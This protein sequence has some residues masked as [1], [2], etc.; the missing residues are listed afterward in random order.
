MRA[1]RVPALLFLA[2]LL[3]RLLFLWPVVA[4]GVPPLYD[5]NDY[6]ERAVAWRGILGTVAAAERPAPGLVTIAYGEGRWPPL[7]PMLLALGL[8]LP[9]AGAGS[10]RLM[11]VLISAATTPLVYLLACRL[12]GE[13]AARAAALLHLA[14]P[15]FVAYSHY[16]WSEST[17]V[18]V[19]LVAVLAT[20]HSEAAATRRGRTWW[21]VAA[22]L[23]LGAAALTRAGALPVLAVPP[24][25][26]CH[27]L[28]RRG[29]RPVVALVVLLCTI[30]VS[31]P[32]LVTLRARE[33]R[34]V[35]LS[36]MTGY[37]AALGNNPWVPAGYGSCWGMEPCKARLLT[38]LEQR[39][40]LVGGDWKSAAAGFAIE[41]IAARPAT[42]LRRAAERFRMLWAPEF[43]AVRHLARGLYPPLPR[44]AAL[45][46]IGAIVGAH[47]F[48]GFAGLAG[49][50]G[51]KTAPPEGRALRPGLLL[52]LVL[53][54][55]LPPVATFAIPR[56]HLPLLAL[57]LPAAGHGIELARARQLPPARRL[58][59]AWLAFAL[60]SASA[61]PLIARGYL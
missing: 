41:Q 39:A 14:Y 8:L 13:R 21:A 15:A 26:L 6:L 55:S 18:L 36:T 53:A 24:A 16:L 34:W 20:V 57:L 33:G 19:L 1:L 25:W 56:L 52:V 23:C 51:W 59:P 54:G 37:N 4:A 28:A 49:L 45:A 22:G 35:P 58:V 47:L 30:A 44:A 32:Y 27:R 42:F 2:S 10:A 12:T 31:L 5:E 40:A 60:L 46:T 43:F 9:G 38:A 48:I 17:Y 3:L 61:L 11:V 50:L 7:H 29:E